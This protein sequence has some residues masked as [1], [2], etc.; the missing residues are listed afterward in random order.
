MLLINRHFLHYICNQ[1][2]QCVVT[3]TTGFSAVTWI[4]LKLMPTIEWSDLK[5]KGESQLLLKHLIKNVKYYNTNQTN[6]TVLPFYIRIPEMSVLALQP[7][8]VTRGSLCSGHHF[9]K[10]KCSHVDG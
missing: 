4:M 3:K 5:I 9:L 8:D 7:R 2:Y 6:P 10:N 1:R